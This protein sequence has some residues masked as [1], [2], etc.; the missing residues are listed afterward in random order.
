MKYP[1]IPVED[2]ESSL[3]AIR[4]SSPQPK[5]SIDWR[6]QGEKFKE[7]LADEVIEGLLELRGRFG[8]PEEGGA[9]YWA[10]FEGHASRVVHSI[11]DTDATAASDPG[12]WLWFT[13]GREDERPVRFVDWRMSV[14]DGVGSALES[15]YG[16]TTNL[17]EGL[18]SRLWLRADIAFEPKDSDPY[19]LALRGDQDLW[20]SHIFR[21]EYAQIR[22][23]AKALIRFQYPHDDSEKP[24][25][26]TDVIRSMVKELRRKHASLA[27]ELLTSEEAKL[28]VEEVHDS[29]IK[30]S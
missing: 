8:E 4:E 1:V 7:H 11:L 2:S 20:R 27:F 24:T 30:Q 9:R 10:R 28:L 22:E 12:F 15:N 25:V 13:F 18:F 21:Q 5:I 16:I 6:G 14:K 29:I 3:A 26:K 17:A 19:R 23:V